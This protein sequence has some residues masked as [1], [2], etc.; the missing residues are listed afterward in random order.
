MPH[1]A[2]MKPSPKARRSIWDEPDPC[3][4]DYW[5]RLAGKPR[6]TIYREELA[7]EVTGIGNHTARH[8]AEWKPARRYWLGPRANGGCEETPAEP[9][10]DRPAEF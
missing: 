2:A 4:E 8:P 10:I 7:A 9:K 3:R 6:P 1:M 5:R